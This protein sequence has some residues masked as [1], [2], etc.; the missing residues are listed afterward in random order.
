MKIAVFGAGAWGFTLANHLSKKG[1]EVN[2]WEFKKEQYTHIKRTGYPLH[3]PYIKIHKNI[4]L[5]Q[6]MKEAVKGA[7]IILL[8]VPAQATRQAAKNIAAYV[9]GNPIFVIVSK[10]IEIKSGKLLSAVVGE[11]LN[12]KRVVALSGPS[13]AREVAEGLPTAVVAAGKAAHTVQVQ[14]IFSSQTLRVYTNT[15]LR[16]VEIGGAVKNV[17]AIACGISYG[18]GLGDNTSAAI[19]TRGLAEITRLGVKLGAKRSTF[20]GLSGLGDILMTSFSLK[21][22][23][24]SFGELI[25]RGIPLR[26]AIKKI[27]MTVEG[28]TTAA[29]VIRLAEKHKIDMPI[30]S[31]IYKILFKNKRSAS[32]ISTLMNRHAKSE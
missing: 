30:T 26:E 9:T 21:S 13:F 27:G 18:L 20:P 24:R 8:C 10:G 29:A 23:N 7:K 32:A 4:S 16:G 19:V 3:F 14:K 2:L 25:G 11:E 31:E 12:T 5:T 6:N 15:D 22:R 1:Y 17:I 28:V